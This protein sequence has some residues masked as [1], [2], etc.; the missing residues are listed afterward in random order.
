MMG[1]FSFLPPLSD[2][3]IPVSY[4]N[5]I[6]SSTIPSNPWI[7]PDAYD[8]DTLSDYMSFNHIKLEYEAIYSSCATDSNLS[9]S[10]YWVHYYSLYYGMSSDPFSHMFYNYEIMMS[11][12]TPWDDHYHKFSFSYSSKDNIS[13]WISS[14]F[15]RVSLNFVSI[16]DISFENNL[17]NI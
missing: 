5:M 12:D 15:V 17:S 2:S 6:Y 4:V 3:S 8:I 14:S 7:I 11:Y 13:D 16:H 1:T 10:I 9:S